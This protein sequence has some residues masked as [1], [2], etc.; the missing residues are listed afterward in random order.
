MAAPSIAKPLAP[1]LRLAILS[2]AAV[3]EVSILDQYMICAVERLSDASGPWAV[4]RLIGAGIVKPRFMYHFLIK[5]REPA[6][7]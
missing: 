4:V 1:Y 6:S 7:G 2:R 5:S 3:A